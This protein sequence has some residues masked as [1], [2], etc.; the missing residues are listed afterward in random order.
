MR[1][2]GRRSAFAV[3]A[4]CALI[5]LALPSTAGAHAV[6]L[7]E[8]P[9]PAAVLRSLPSELTLVF[10]EEVL[11]RY[12]R[13]TVAGSN[14]QPIGGPAR[15]AGTVVTIPLRAGGRGSYT[16]RWRMVAA[17]DGHA[18]E[19]TYTF[20]VGVKPRPPAPLSSLDVP[21]VPQ[22]LAWLQFVG[23][24][25][26]GGLLTC[27]G[28]LWVPAVNRL[29][30]AEAPDA[31]AAMRVAAI[32]AVVAVHAGVLA[33]LVGSYPIV[34]GG[35]SAFVNALIEQIRSG[36]HL[37]QAWTVTTFL[38]FGVLT[39]I[40]AAW[41]TPSKR[42]PLLLGSGALALGLAFGL[43]WASHPDS[44]GTLALVADFLHLV[45]AALWVGGLLSLVILGASTRS[46]PRAER[47]A[48]VR[49]C[50]ERFSRLVLPT[51]AVVALAGLY[52]ALR[53]LPS[54]SAITSTGYGLMLL[55]K[56]LIVLA[57][58]SLGGYH[59]R[60]VIPRLKAGLPAAALR[61]TLT[62]EMG[63]LLAVLAIAAVI[64]QSAPPVSHSKPAALAHASSP[65]TG[66]SVRPVAG[67]VLTSSVGPGRAAAQAVQ[68]SSWQ[69]SSHASGRSAPA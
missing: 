55:I 28:L 2:C 53:E 12:A 40:V 8:T 41:V 37:G 36:T 39:L 47:E 67:A 14:G 59:R 22:V 33:F 60:L 49:A 1:R 24:V 35:L 64:S 29:G 9:A 42:E 26:V 61:R 45:A 65:A 15:V 30:H 68:V 32:G 52:L 5:L 43:S 25:L 50:M 34:G 38:W 48:V 69:S 23:I 57:A 27:R 58:L 17:D 62:L 63:L 54:V 13:V 19:G 66:A 7:T 46:L 20:G 56:S 3:A 44:R 51:V 6:P 16:V 11:V 31:G 10:D 18:T 21:V 4:A